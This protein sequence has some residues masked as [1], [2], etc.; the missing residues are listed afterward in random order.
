MRNG[1]DYG[2]FKWLL[3]LS[4]CCF[5]YIYIYIYC[6]CVCVCV[7]VC[8]VMFHTEHAFSY[9]LSIVLL[10]SDVTYMV[11]WVSEKKQKIE[12]SKSCLNNL[13]NNYVALY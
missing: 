11:D 12:L 3:L 9:I 6:V 1:I 7:C 4:L 8:A 10:C 13:A 5:I 2:C